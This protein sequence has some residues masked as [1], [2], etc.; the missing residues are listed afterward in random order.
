MT[1]EL[2]LTIIQIAIGIFIAVIIIL[3]M[4]PKSRK[5]LAEMQ[6]T[7]HRKQR[8]EDFV[9]G[10]DFILYPIYWLIKLIIGIFKS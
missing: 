4:I 1:P 2:L 10:M 9:F 5:W 6:P 7:P 8:S 3:L